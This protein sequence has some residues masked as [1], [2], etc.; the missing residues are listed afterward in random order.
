MKSGSQHPPYG[1]TDP[2][3]WTVLVG[4]QGDRQP[5]KGLRGVCWGAVPRH[6]FLAP[7]TSLL[8]CSRSVSLP[9]L[10]LAPGLPVLSSQPRP[11]LCTPHFL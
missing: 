4:C 3:P 11:S 6:H 8:L 1:G 7:S 2:A 5:M 10:L 9:A